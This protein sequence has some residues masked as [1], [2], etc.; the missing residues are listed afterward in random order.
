[1]EFLKFINENKK[2]SYD[3]IKNI[4]EEKYKLEIRLDENKDFYMIS[5]TNKSNIECNLVKQCTGIIVDKETNNILHYF[6]DKAYD[7]TNC[8]NNNTNKLE[9]IN[10]KNCFISPYINGNIIKIFNYKENWKFATSKN[11]NIKS[12]KVNNTP[13]Y[14]I[15]EESVLK[16]FETFD[17]FLNTLD[18]TYCYSIILNNGK[19][20]II[21]K[22]YLKTL[23]EHFNFN[24]FYPLLDFKC[25]NLEKYILIEKDDNDNI[26]KKLHISKKYIKELTYYNKNCNL[27]NKCFNKMCKFKH[28]INFDL[29]KNFKEYTVLKKKSNL[30]RK[31]NDP[32]V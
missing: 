15:F 16:L 7:F 1:M 14:D 17:D 24:N 2:L 26:I 5:L 10:I 30:Y 31:N 19:I 27:N 6:G 8:N 12:F 32:I 4:L 29:E 11:T 3:D 13:L 28:P 9:N 25:N 20:S 23:E 21:N 22:I 18:K